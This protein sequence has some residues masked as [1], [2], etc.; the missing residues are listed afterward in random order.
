M[1]EVGI[2][3]PEC[4]RLHGCRGSLKK[5]HAIFYLFFFAKITHAPADFQTRRVEAFQ[6]VRVEE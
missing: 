2:E 4:G 1:G 3:F 6:F 5:V